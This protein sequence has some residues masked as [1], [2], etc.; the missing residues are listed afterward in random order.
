MLS[1]AANDQESVVTKRPD[2]QNTSSQASARGRH[3]GLL[4]PER[5][6]RQQRP[7]AERR[8]GQPGN[9]DAEP[10]SLLPDTPRSVLPR[11]KGGPAEGMLYWKRLKACR[12]GNRQ[13]Y[14]GL[15]LQF[16]AP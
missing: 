16:G 14:L 5:V 11:G 2:F 6:P 7:A 1:E 3:S 8:A 15:N 9:A 4:S 12:S 10:T 13:L